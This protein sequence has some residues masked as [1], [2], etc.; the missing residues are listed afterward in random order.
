M[1]YK[2]VAYIFDCSSDKPLLIKSM[3]TEPLLASGDNYVECGV[4][5]FDTEIDNNFRT[6][7]KPNT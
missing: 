2:D 1:T 3:S 6:I 5:I 7:I 4:A